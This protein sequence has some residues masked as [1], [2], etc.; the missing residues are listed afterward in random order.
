MHI[1]FIMFYPF[2]CLIIFVAFI[3]YLL[4][5]M[6]IKE[7]TSE[8]DLY[9][10]F[11]SSWCLKENENKIIDRELNGFW[12]IDWNTDKNS[13]I[14][15]I[16]EKKI[17][18]NLDSE[19]KD[20][21]IVLASGVFAGDYAH[22]S[23]MFKNN[24]FVQADISYN[25]SQEEIF[26]DLEKGLFCFKNKYMELAKFISEKYGSPASSVCDISDKEK[27]YSSILNGNASIY[28][29]WIFSNSAI[30]SLEI[31]N[32]DGGISVYLI[33]TILDMEE[34]EKERTE[35]IKRDI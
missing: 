35:I 21:A 31:K 6:I 19:K 25:F 32:I 27:M 8:S 23:F 12:G 15:K 24:S 22:L 26:D 2:V 7:K 28:M 20:Y 10:S 11:Q 5:K 33:Y 9:N 16:K 1:I 4:K 13:F 14:E 18:V 34:I 3:V 30:I 17:K 29:E